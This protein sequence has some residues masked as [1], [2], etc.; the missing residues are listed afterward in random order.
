ML[1]LPLLAFAIFIPTTV[2]ADTDQHPRTIYFTTG[3]HQDLLGLPLD[4]KA[5]I[6]ATFEAIRERYKVQRVWW[7]GGQDEVW[8]KQF[9]LREENR[10][11]ARLWQWWKD[12]SYEKVGTNRI[13]VRAARDRGMQIWM[14]YGLVDNGSQADAGYVGF[15]YAIEDRLRVKN[16]EWAPVN[17]FGTWRQGG[18]IEFA[19]PGARKGMTDYLTKHLVDGGYDGIAF[20]TYAENFSQRYDDE[21]G[22]NQPIVDEFKKRHGVDI[23]SQPFDKEAWARL[24]GE[25]L[26]QFLREL[27]ASLSRH[28]KKIA[29]CVDGKAPH[30]PTVWNIDGGIR[31]AGRIHFDLATWTKEHL[32]DELTVYAPA[33]DEAIATCVKTCQGTRT[34]ASVFRTRGPMP[35]GAPRI[36]FV[37]QDVESGFDW[38]NYIDWP[39]EKLTPQPADA[40]TKGDVHARRRLLLAIARKKQKATTAEIVAATKA[41]DIF[42]RRAAL[43]ALAVINDAA[44]IPAVE[45]ALLDPEN[46][47]RWQAALVLG[48]LAAPHL[49]EKLFE[50]VARQDSTFQ[51]DFRA[52]PEVLKARSASKSAPLG[53]KERTVIVG[54]VAS[55]DVRMREVALYCLKLI[56]APATPE[57]EKVLLHVI[58][59]DPSSFAKELAMTNLRSSFGASERVLSA[60]R[61]AMKDRDAS[62]QVRAVATL[63]EA[64]SA[65]DVPKQTRDQGL[66]EVADFFR[67]Y[68][69]GKRPDADWG[70]REVGNA[71]L[72]F[73]ADG[74]AILETMIADKSNQRLADL[75]WRIL[76]IRQGDR[77][78]PSTEAADRRAHAQ[79]P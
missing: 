48:Q 10:M 1:S 51:F 31:T 34:L 4:S 64:L 11:F 40:L 53:S 29:V 2:V 33:S 77:F 63:A 74:R 66:N 25:Y 71:L 45:R 52:V 41:P 37:G 46:S 13:A 68:A 59:N 6:E 38:E 47:V 32:V 19:Y 39:D 22:F 49:V 20:L 35:K 43:R 28:G 54:K 23:R 73:G 17:R 61:A 26:T 70:W 76:Y 7:R 36:M 79:R 42:V 60:L 15:P 55:D 65:K 57:V 14:A 58:R 72:H 62:V 3:D 75:A 30:L 69:G 12:L 44:A 21:F 56:G 8:G 67:I 27:R 24:R 9:H 50:V 18:P 5:T 78:F 16:P